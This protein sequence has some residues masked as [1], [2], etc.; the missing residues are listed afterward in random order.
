[1]KIGAKIT[2]DYK[3]V[4][5][6]SWRITENIRKESV[7]KEWKFVSIPPTKC[8]FLGKRTL[9]NGSVLDGC[10]NPVMYIKAYLVKSIED[11]NNP[12]YV[13]QEAVSFNTERR[14]NDL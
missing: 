6:G 5:T 13:L 1:M 3:L 7:Y 12:F 2:V 14:D 11:N 9:S 8:V 4:R 10:Y